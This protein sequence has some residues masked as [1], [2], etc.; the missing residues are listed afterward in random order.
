[1]GGLR[2]HVSVLAGAECLPVVAERL[3]VI[4]PIDG[5]IVDERFPIGQPLFDFGPLR[6]VL[7]GEAVVQIDRE[8][9]EFNCRA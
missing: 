9:C 4:V 7:R 6:R 1:M 5:P 8:P 3:A 2:C